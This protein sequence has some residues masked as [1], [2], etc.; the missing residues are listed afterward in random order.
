MKNLSIYLFF[1]LFLSACSDVAKTLRNEK[2][3]TTDEFLVK[4]RDPLSMPPDYDKLPVPGSIEQE[5]KKDNVTD[6]IEKIFKIEE[7]KNTPNSSESS[8]EKT[9]LDQI[10][11]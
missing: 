9:I 7:E 2:T 11:K 4:K 8:T 3:K 1:I 6:N 5:K 10:K